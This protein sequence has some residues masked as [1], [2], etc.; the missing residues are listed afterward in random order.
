MWYEVM[1]HAPGSF[2]IIFQ[3]R[4]LMWNEVILLIF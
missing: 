4:K 2:R 3:Y 1:L